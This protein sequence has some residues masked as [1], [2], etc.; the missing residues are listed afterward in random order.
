[1]DTYTQVLQ[2]PKELSDTTSSMD[3]RKQ[4]AVARSENNVRQ[5]MAYLPHDC[6]RS[7]IK[8]GWDVTT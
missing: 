8:M 5:W 2:F 6:I 1:M 3:A 7:M 4:A